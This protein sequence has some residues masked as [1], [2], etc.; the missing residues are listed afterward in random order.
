MKSAFK[1]LDKLIVEMGHDTDKQAHAKSLE[2][3]I[4]DYEKEFISFPLPT[5]LI[6]MI[7][8]KLYEM[9]LKQRIEPPF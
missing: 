4:Q 3:A 1:T 7:E 8:L 6:G 9:K 2:E 5:T